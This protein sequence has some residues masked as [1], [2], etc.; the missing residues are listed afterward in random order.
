MKNNRN[1]RTKRNKR[2]T[3][4]Q[5]VSTPGPKKIDNTEE[6]VKICKK[7]MTLCNTS[8]YNEMDP[9]KR[10]QDLYETNKVFAQSHP[11]VYKMITEEKKY[12]TEA[13]KKY[14]I[15]YN[16]TMITPDQQ[17]ML[18]SY[19][20]MY[21]EIS[22]NKNTHHNMREFYKY[23]ADCEQQMKDDLER[24]K[25]IEKEEAELYDKKEQERLENNKQELFEFFSK[26]K[27][28]REKTEE[29]KAAQCM[30]TASSANIVAASSQ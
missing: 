13:F 17:P 16:K 6:L 11:V 8:P 28:L 10:Y 23:K 22:R 24:V 2:K 19:Y 27:Q 21:L 26:L 3:T 15:K 20:L 25:S 9:K 29:F 4:T 30:E 1:R 7:L 12:S 5:P 14:L 18:G